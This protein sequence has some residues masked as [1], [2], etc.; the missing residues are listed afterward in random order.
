MFI[1]K[2]IFLFFLA[3]TGLSCHAQTVSVKVKK[4]K[5]RIK[6][7]YAD[8]FEVELQA[9]PEEVEASLTK[10]MKS[11]GK[12]KSV[13]NFLVVNEP[14]IQGRP[15]TTPVYGVNKQVGN[16]ISAWVGIKTDDWQKDDVETVNHDLEKMLHDFGVTFYREKIQKQIDESVRAGQAVE[17]Q[18]QRLQ[19]QN[20]D[21]NGKI[22]DNKREKIQ[23]EKALENNRIALETLIKR[24]EKNKKDQ[25]S[26]AMA[27]EQIKKVIEMHRERQRK[28]N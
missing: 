15:Y 11:L 10:F 28:V 21:L 2:F 3:A 27:G 23:L 17:R 22:E 19:N 18:Q 14:V 1:K 13:E 20:R 9:T 6:N 25:D 24:L 8:G 26:V 12:S 5:A 4:E 7:E 16:M